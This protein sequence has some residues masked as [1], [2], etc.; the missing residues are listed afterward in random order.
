MLK[1]LKTRSSKIIVIIVALFVILAAIL[2]VNT[3]NERPQD[4]GP[5]LE[6]I[7]KRHTGCPLP[8]PIG[9]LMLCSAEPGEE[10]YFG[11]DLGIEEIEQYF[12]GATPIQ[13]ENRVSGTAAAFNFTDLG[14]TTPTD[15]FS[16]FPTTTKL[17]CSKRTL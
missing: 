17:E 2:A 8:L 1:I 16:F 9:Y 3:Y 10:Y 15:G 4:L 7:G 14:F 5:E 11:T 6:Y 12:K 13:S